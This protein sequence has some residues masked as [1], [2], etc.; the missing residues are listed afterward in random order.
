MNPWQIVVLLGLVIML[1]AWII[2]RNRDGAQ[3]AGIVDE[4][5]QAL[6]LY[7][8][9]ITDSNR[10]VVEHLE[11]L[12]NQMDEEH[13]RWRDRVGQLEEEIAELREIVAS[14]GDPSA[15]SRDSAF[16]NIHERYS[17]LIELKRQG[18]S[19]HEIVKKTGMNHGEVN[20]ILMLAA[21]E[22]MNLEDR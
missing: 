4:V 16:G 18:F 10:Q 1:Y 12:K 7:V 22:E 8:A 9:E 14:L 6:D 3:D 11:R 13:D 2:L 17:R 21:Q 15:R 5:D 19:T 20:F